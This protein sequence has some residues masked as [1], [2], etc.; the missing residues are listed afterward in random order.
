MRMFFFEGQIRKIALKG[1][2]SNLLIK[3][4]TIYKL[5][6]LLISYYQKKHIEWIDLYTKD[7]NIEE[8]GK[9]TTESYAL[10]ILSLL[11][12]KKIKELNI[13]W[14]FK[15]YAEWM[16]YSIKVLNVKEIE[17]F[18]LERYASEVLTK[19][20]TEKIRINNK[21]EKLIV[22]YYEKEH[23]EWVNIFE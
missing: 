14:Y 11:I 3:M 23:V 13:F 15:E 21:I 2:A 18:V 4:K 1:Y 9:L 7:V 17:I 6:E 22:N 20:K 16:N 19:T 10:K 5:K 8:I 12:F